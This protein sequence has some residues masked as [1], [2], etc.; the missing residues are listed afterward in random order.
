MLS[1]AETR[2]YQKRLDGALERA[3]GAVLIIQGKTLS[4]EQRETVGR[5]RSFVA[6]A[7]QV[8]EQDLIG[9]VNL[10]ERADLLSK[11]LLDRLK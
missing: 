8:R 5:I 11:D 2:E 1:Q 6:Q 10:A 3:K 9:A 7:E 4:G